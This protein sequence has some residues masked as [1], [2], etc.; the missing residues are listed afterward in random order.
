V[1]EK[2]VALLKR[3]EE[4][5]L[6][7]TAFNDPDETVALLIEARDL[8]ADLT[9]DKQDVDMWQQIADRIFLGKEL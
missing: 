9:E 6:I 8:L 5:I 2:N 1:E 3:I 4:R 7:E